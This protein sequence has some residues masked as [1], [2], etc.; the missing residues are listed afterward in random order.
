MRSLF[1]FFVLICSS[2]LFACDDLNLLRHS[3][4]SD[5]YYQYAPFGKME[6]VKD[7]VMVSTQDKPHR[8][9]IIFKEKPY[10]ITLFL[11]IEKSSIGDQKII[12][13]TYKFE[14]TDDGKTYENSKLV[15]LKNGTRKIGIYDLV[16]GRRMIFVFNDFTANEWSELNC[17][18]IPK[19]DEFVRI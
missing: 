2:R 5:I 18:N 15:K 12:D 8:L 19:N 16:H 14:N 17:P 11:D 10:K 13:L 7:H 9:T 3:I 1:V 4:K 6:V